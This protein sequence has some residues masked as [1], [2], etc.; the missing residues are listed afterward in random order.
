M[1]DPKRAPLTPQQPNAPETSPGLKVVSA[2][3]LALLGGMYAFSSVKLFSAPAI[4]I[5]ACPPTRK[6]TSQFFCE[7]GH[8][9][10]TPIP[11]QYRGLYE[12][13]LHLLVAFAFMVA[14]FLLFRSARK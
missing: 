12:G 9:I 6:L 1:Y 3:I 10:L 14:A 13:A 11:A 5:T 8:L 7:L 4:A 2:L